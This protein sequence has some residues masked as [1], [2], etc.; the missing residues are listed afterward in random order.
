MTSSK[1]S[2]L[3]VIGCC[4]L[5]VACGQDEAVGGPSLGSS[6]D[7]AGGD[8]GTIADAENDTG[9]EQDTSI[10]EDTTAPE[11]TGTEQDTSTGGCVQD[12]D[13]EGKVT[14]Q[15]CFVALCQDGQCT[16]GLAADGSD[17]D[18]G[19]A[20][21]EGESCSASKCGGGKNVCGC[22]EDTDCEDNNACTKDSCGDDGK[23][24]YE[25]EDADCDD[26]DAC[27]EDTKCQT[28]GTCGGGGVTDCDDGNDCTLDTCDA[29]GG[30]K[31]ENSAGSCDDGN[32]CTDISECKEGKCVG[33][34]KKCDD[35]NPC[36]TDSCDKDK[37]CTPQN[38]TD[39]CDDGDT[40]TDKD[41]CK[42]GKCTSG[43]KVDCDDGNPCTDD[44]CDKAKG[45][46]SSPAKDGGQCDD[47]NKC[48][49]K[50]ACK[51]GA[52]EGS[53]K[54]KC[55]DGNP[56]TDDTCDKDKGCSTSNNTAKCS[57]NKT[58]ASGECK[59]GKC[60]LGAGKGCDD[61]NACTTDT[62]DPSKGC[63]YAPAK[64]GDKC[65]DGDA[66]TEKDGCSAGKCTGAKLD[67]GD[68]NLCTDDTCDPSK[69]C[70]WTPNTA[71]CDDGNKCTSNDKCAKGKCTAGT[72]SDPKVAC[73]D[74]N[75]CTNDTCDKEKGCQH[76]A[77]VS[78]KPCDGTT[79]KGRCY[80]AFTG[81]IN[82]TNA[83]N[84]CKTW[85]GTLATLNAADE[86]AQVY[87]LF[88]ATCGST[89]GAHIGGTDAAKE[90]TWT[91]L[92]NS[93]WKYTN[94]DT[95][96]PNDY[97]NNQDGLMLRPNGKWN[98]IGTTVSLNCRICER[99][100]PA[101]KCDDG[102]VC[103]KNDF[104]KDGKCQG[105]TNDGCDDGKQCTLDSCDD[106]TGKCSWSAKTGKCEDG[107][108][109]TTGDE[110]KAG[111]C[112]TGKAVDCDDKNVC[113]TDSCDL[114]TGK[115]AYK[116]VN[117]PCSDGNA[118]TSPDACVSGKCLGAKK[119]CSDGDPCTTD[120]CDKVK[121][122]VFTKIAG[123][124]GCKTDAECDDSD[125]CTD[126]SCDA[127]TGKCAAK[128]N[129][130]P[131]DNNDPCTFGDKCDGKGKC[132]TG[133][134][135]ACDDDNPCTVDSCDKA[136]GCINTNAKDG[137]KCD[138]GKACTTGDG[139]KAGKCT[140][141]KDD[142]DLL[143]A[144]F[145]CGSSTAGWLLQSEG[146]NPVLSW[147]IDNTPAI[148]PAGK[149]CSLNFN[150]GTDYCRP[151]NNG[152]YNP[153]AYARTP[154]L[155]AT[156]ATGTPRISFWTYYDLDGV[157]STTTDTPRILIYQV[158]PGN[159]PLL[160]NF[161]LGKSANDMKKWRFVSVAVPNIKGKE[162]RAYFY[163]NPSSG[164]GGNTGKGWFIDDLRIT[165]SG[166]QVPEDCTDGKDNDGDTKI[167]CVDSDCSSQAVCKEICDDGKDNDLDD[168]IDCKDPECVGA[169]NCVCQ[170]KDCDDKEVCTT[171]S[172]DAKTGKC[173]NAPNKLVCDDG[174]ACTNGDTC[175]AGKCLGLAK[176]C[177]DGDPCTADSCDAKTGKCVNK[178]IAGC[179]GCKTAAQCDD[180]NACTNDSCDLKT[181]KCVNEPNKNPCDTG[182]VCTFGDTCDGKGNCKVGS[183]KTCDDG[184]SCTADTCDAKTGKC[185]YK[186]LADG[187]KCDDGKACS[188]GDACKA[189]TCTATKFDCPVLK[190]TFDCGSSTQG[191][192]LQGATNGNPPLKWAVD[193]TPKVESP[194]D[195]GASAGCN[196]NY[197]DGTDYCRPAGNNNCYRPDEDAISPT[198]SG[199]GLTGSLKLRFWGYI[200]VDAGTTDQPRLRLVQG[201]NWQNPLYLVNLDKTKMKQ[202][203]K[204]EIDVPLIKDKTGMYMRIDF[205]GY[206]NSGAQGANSGQ[207]IFIDDLEITS[208]SS[209]G[210]TPKEI[211]GDGKDNDGNKL[212]DCADPACKAETSCQEDCG[213]GKDNDL[214]DK[215]DCLDTDCIGAATCQPPFFSQSFECTDKGWEFSA[216]KNNVAFAID[217]TPASVTPK[218]GGCTLNFNNGTNFCGVANCANTFNN[219]T[220]GT[221]TW[222]KDVDATNLKTLSAEYWSYDH[223]Q[224]PT[225]NGAF[226]DVGFLQVSTNNFAGC[227]N[228]N[229]TTC[230]WSQVNCNNANTK[231]Y[232]TP[233][234]AQTWKTW[235]KVTVDLKDFVGKKFKMRYRFSTQ[236]NSS[237]SLPGWFIDDMKMFATK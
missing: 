179:G 62:C 126:N 30:C 105:G 86:D 156:G 184:N 14:L 162:I 49:D 205:T 7:G 3:I 178:A 119:E 101:P 11:D 133:K 138:D 89:S 144:T 47:G 122:C 19:D 96:Q 221:A 166:D 112:A 237:N 65:D 168:Q 236:G 5:L 132:V 44:S 45:C 128:N 233:R 187:A 32:P 137:A 176:S 66:C 220:A 90:D 13:C 40:C 230:P 78:P 58:C 136:K 148:A 196:L 103:T 36:T 107:D 17:C 73:D 20:C 218:T 185:A 134:G 115:C 199:V 149:G 167:D 43:A 23:C 98:D 93:T 151:G 74:K 80:K 53:A 157:G 234:N 217:K 203:V 169:G 140:P 219:R 235:S 120:S 34:A 116:N 97:Q 123:C 81:A 170:L 83:N 135:N 158:Q 108:L 223:G 202:W 141:T 42:D 160:Y 165:K 191:W 2:R 215:T 79:F 111:K 50:D 56:C 190:Y 159:D 212:V 109:C 26:G 175:G 88:Q 125:P 67:C 201:N 18:D 209:A 227:C 52:C 55:D 213:D 226:Q 72:A 121:G 139:C 92:D 183:N 70:S 84:S 64:D 59:D 127:N 61:N 194:K 87:K 57:D 225:G 82:W 163:L 27:T 12:S 224:E 155:D 77:K 1:L 113:T 76:T 35:G 29:Q 37:G 60:A 181:G 106:K 48:T 22:K 41:V 15:V 39:K 204:Y 38:N 33:E 91:W 28:D 192:T 63:V 208:L 142:C 180:A 145:D 197:N 173:V 150:D 231:S 100:I 147:A 46:Q 124:K 104:C 131:C 211:C 16:V 214:D 25:N 110:C 171:D 10:A 51:A 229:S 118:C 143:F 153:N 188:T 228:G 69:G 24:S 164:A 75:G 186:N 198:F 117:A 152:C 68:D 85:G 9:T 21:T 200:D 8:I 130:A 54:V 207:G 146:G 71:N 95:D 177:S 182:D 206:P 99:E 102:S 4:L 114:K 195:K 193:N 31:S 174:N 161:T 189:G 172:C 210:A 6:N 216:A 232:L 154:T 94:W 129:T 222:S